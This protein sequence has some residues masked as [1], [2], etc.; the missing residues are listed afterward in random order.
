MEQACYLFLAFAVGVFVGWKLHKQERKVMTNMMKPPAPN[1]ILN[2]SVVARRNNV[3][4]FQT[5]KKI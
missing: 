2:R 3:I 1:N 5:K 4:P